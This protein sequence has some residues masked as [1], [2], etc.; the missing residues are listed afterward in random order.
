LT[1]RSNQ[2]RFGKV[3]DQQKPLKLRSSRRLV[4]RRLHFGSLP[5]NIFLWTFGPV[6]AAV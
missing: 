1:I 2:R 4:A 5:A 3:P 6:V